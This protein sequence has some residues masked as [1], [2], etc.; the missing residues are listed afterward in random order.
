MC[1]RKFSKLIKK[2]DS[3]G[4][5]ITLNYKGSSTYQ[6]LFGGVMSIISKCLVLAYFGTQIN[7]V[8]QKSSYAVT[9]TQS[10]I[11]LDSQQLTLNLTTSDIDLAVKVSYLGPDAT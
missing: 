1:Q 7:T 11:D 10:F 2:Q 5:P 6:S 8:Y 9:S 3:F 4:V